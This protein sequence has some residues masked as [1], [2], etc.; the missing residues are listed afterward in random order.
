[1]N[2][3]EVHLGGYKDVYL[4]AFGVLITRCYILYPE[5]KLVLLVKLIMI[6]WLSLPELIGMFHIN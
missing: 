1:M 2:D 6:R 5:G 3:D 4:R